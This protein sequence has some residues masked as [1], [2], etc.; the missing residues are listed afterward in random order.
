MDL[1]KLLTRKMD[2]PD[3]LQQA[4]AMVRALYLVMLLMASMAVWEAMI[5]VLRRMVSLY[6]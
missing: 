4:V 3:L 6:F 2:L 1:F 5:A